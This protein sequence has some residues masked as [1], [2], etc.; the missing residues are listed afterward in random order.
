MFQLEQRQVVPPYKP[1]LK[2]DRDLAHFDTAFTDED[3]SM[4][5]DEPLVTINRLII[6]NDDMQL[7]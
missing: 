1:V 4:T 3:P 2:D 7:N 6:N 5:P